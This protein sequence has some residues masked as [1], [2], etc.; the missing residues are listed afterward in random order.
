[1]PELNRIEINFA[2]LRPTGFGNFYRA[3]RGKASFFAGWGRAGW[4][5]HPCWIPLKSFVLE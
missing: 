3:G 1:M 4:A 5:V 2:P